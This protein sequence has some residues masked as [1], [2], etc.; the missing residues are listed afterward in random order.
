MQVAA[1]KRL[2]QIAV[3]L[4]L[5]GLLLWWIDPRELGRILASAD[6][7][8]L[9]LALIIATGNRILMAVKWN[10]LLAAQG[11]ELS[12]AHAVRVY[13]QSTFLGVFLPPTVGGDVVRAWL[14]HR[15]EA[16]L[17]EIA[18][19]ILVERVL[20]LLTLAVFG[21]VAAALLPSMIGPGTVDQTR[22]FLIVA[23]AGIVSLGLF[24]FSFSALAERIADAMARRL[25]GLPVIGRLATM[26]ARIH[27]AYRDYRNHRG[28][29]VLFFLL[30]MLENA[31]PILRAWV[32][33]TAI[34]VT[35]S[36][37]WFLII[38]PLEL[39]LIRI[40]L[41]FDG[42][43]IRE[44]L[45]VWF[46]AFAGVAESAG[47]AV[48]LTNHLLFLVAVLPGGFF[49]LMDPAARRGPTIKGTG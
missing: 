49:H 43:G 29:L 13:Y 25:S 27:V 18:S 8:L 48:G 42:F 2:I 16:R 7:P 37:M 3:S 47:F 21:A 17:P 39:V 45:F 11:I 28:T 40:P 6:A 32:V 4:G 31:L 38:V 30:T 34:G 5:I 19:S 22:L 41:S 23:G 24:A 20:G 44:G 35:V 46:L 12:W 36:P 26:L 1:T 9:F 33:A 10:V 14:V 15:S